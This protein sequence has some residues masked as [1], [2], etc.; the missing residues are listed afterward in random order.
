MTI[1]REYPQTSFM[2]FLIS[3][4]RTWSTNLLSTNHQM[5]ELML[6]GFQR[7]ALLLILDDASVWIFESEFWFTA[8]FSFPIE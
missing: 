3:L 2:S 8:N 6:P 7:H 4:I 1:L 5:Y